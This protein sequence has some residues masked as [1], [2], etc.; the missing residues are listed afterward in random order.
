MSGIDIAALRRMVTAIA[1][2]DPQGSFASR[3]GSEDRCGFARARSFTLGLAGADAAFPHGLAGDALHEV[4]AENPGAHM[5]ATGFALAFAARAAERSTQYRRPI[6]WIEEEKAAS[7]YGGLYPPGL[8][9]FGIDPSRL[10]I[11][12]CPTAQDVLKAANDALEAGSGGKASHLVS[13]VVASVTGQPKCLDLTA[14]RRLLLATE[15]AQLPV[16][17][18]RSHRT[19][20]QS[21][22]VSRWR[23]APA[24]SRSSGASAPGKPAFSAVLERNRHGTCGQWIM[25]WNNETLE[26]GARE[27]DGRTLV[28]RP[29]VS[30]SADRPASP[31]RSA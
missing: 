19:A 2:N 31:R 15:T 10:L 26:F 27:R 3:T 7:E 14:S 21:A 8:H 16:I 28:S 13:G 17:L 20:V 24:P 23:V 1:G 6:I 5:A 25:E 18:L 29:V 4:F 12:R 30:V 22:A 9:A 11:V